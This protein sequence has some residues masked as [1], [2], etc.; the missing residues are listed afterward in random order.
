MISTL[1]KWGMRSNVMY[2][3][4]VASIGLAFASWIASNRLEAAGVE[5]AD[6]WGIF[7]GE[8]A[9]TFFAMGVA[10]RMEETREQAMEASDQRADTEDR[11]GGYA[12][13]SSAMR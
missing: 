2:T 3:A 8:W 5:R 9:P 12:A 7:V 6:R 4:G 11:I 1:H 13:R 10:L